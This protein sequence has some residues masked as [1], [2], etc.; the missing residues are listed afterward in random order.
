MATPPYP[1]IQE[2][3]AAFAQNLSRGL[4][5]GLKAANRQSAAAVFRSGMEDINTDSARLNET[6]CRFKLVID[7]TPDDS[8]LRILH[9]QGVFPHSKCTV[10]A[11]CPECSCMADP[12]GVGA[13]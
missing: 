11:P 5:V 4:G 8:A 9:A 1:P 3:V 2:I 12:W 10:C 13:E 7:A 6:I